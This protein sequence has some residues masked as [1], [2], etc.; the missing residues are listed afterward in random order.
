M[1]VIRAFF[2]FTALGGT[3][4]ALPAAAG[5]DVWLTQQQYDAAAPFPG[6]VAV[7]IIDEAERLE[8][9]LF[10]AVSRAASPQ[11]ARQAALQLFLSPDWPQKET[12][13]K[14]AWQTVARAHQLGITKTP[15]VVI[16]DRFVVYGT[17]RTVEAHRLAAQYR[18]GDQ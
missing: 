11:A 10:S 1:S 6:D 12:Q 2:M 8:A 13:L 17:T 9:V 18:G 7:H 16:D 15:A 3:G 4:M 5:T 14:L